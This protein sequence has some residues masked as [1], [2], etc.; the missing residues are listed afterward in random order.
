MATKVGLLLLLVIM[1][2]ILPDVSNSWSK[3]IDSLEESPGDW[4][5]SWPEQWQGTQVVV[6]ELPDGELAIGDFGEFENVEELTDAAAAELDIV[7]SKDS[8]E[9]GVMITSFDGHEANGWE[10]TIDGKR[11]SV[12][13]SEAELTE[14]SVVRWSPA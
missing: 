10:F 4:D 12:G 3:E 6:F 14:D 7:V 1:I 5:D 11:S 8:Y 9:I 2:L 13:I